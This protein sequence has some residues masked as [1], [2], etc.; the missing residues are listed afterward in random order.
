[1]NSKLLRIMALRILSSIFVLFLVISLVFV[2]IHLAPGNP[3]QKYLSPNLSQKLY[4]EVS[5]SYN[6]NSSLFN[7]YLAFVK[8]VING[9]LGISY[10]YR[11]PVISVIK[12]YLSFTIIFGFISFFL[13]MIVAFILVY[14]TFIFKSE[15]FEKY[16][17]NINLTIYSIPIFISSILLIYIFS[18]KLNILP[19][20]GLKSFDFYNLNSFQ[21]VA[22]Y[23]QHLILPF[24]ASSFAA[25]P[26]YYKYFY[27][28]IKNIVNANFVKNLEM[29][30]LNKNK[31]LFS[32]IIPNSLNTLIAVAGVELG[33]LLG[34]SVLVETIFGLP[35]MGRLTMMAVVS[36]DY[37]LIIATVL[38]ASLIVLVINL[39]SDIIRTIIDKR[40]LKSLLS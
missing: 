8:N 4:E 15:K 39:V 27:G 3:S 6:L 26:I 23:T 36:R 37:P 19:S 20:S 25:I 7:Q 38:F 30:G 32:N 2:I 17:V 31:I 29:I 33:L 22:D 21:K 11:Q 24:I 28:S 34:G 13:Q 14:L 12:S 40:L 1:M 18:F 5:E 10:N 35:G 9:D 16:L